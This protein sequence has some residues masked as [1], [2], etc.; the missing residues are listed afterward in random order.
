VVVFSV[1]Y[2]QYADAMGNA[3]VKTPS[4]KLVFQKD[5]KSPVSSIHQLR[6]KVLICEGTKVSRLDSPIP[7]CGVVSVLGCQLAACACYVW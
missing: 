1:D 2:A 7:A 5:L 6:D 3:S 4:L